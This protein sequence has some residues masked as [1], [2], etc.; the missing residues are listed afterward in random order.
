MEQFTIY[1]LYWKEKKMN[2]INLTFDKQLTRLAGNPYG[3]EVF[4][5]QV[6]EKIDWSGKNEIIF[7]DQIKR[8]A[9]SFIQGFAKEILK[10]VDKND[11]E[12]LFIFKASSDELEKKI[13]N[14]ILF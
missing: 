4:D 12:K 2:K 13:L 10:K 8:I 7:P 11:V 6:R 14:N 3:A 5:K 1:H 9:I